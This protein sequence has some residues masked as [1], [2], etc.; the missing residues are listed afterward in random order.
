MRNRSLSLIVL[1]AVMIVRLA[2]AASILHSVHHSTATAASPPTDTTAMADARRH[3]G[4]MP[5]NIRTSGDRVVILS[6]GPTREFD[7]NPTQ[8]TR[9]D[10]EDDLDSDTIKPAPTPVFVPGQPMMDPTPSRK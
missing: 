1:F 4:Q 2:F 5:D 10:S 9:E 6:D 8:A 7:D 3:F